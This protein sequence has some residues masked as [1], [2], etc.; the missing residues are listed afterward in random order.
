MQFKKAVEKHK[1]DHYV[2]MIR[3]IDLNLLGS[4][5]NEDIVY[6]IKG[7]LERGVRGGK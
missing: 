3:P 5:T 2:P 6:V 4:F 1:D 7:E